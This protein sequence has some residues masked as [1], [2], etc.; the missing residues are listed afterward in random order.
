MPALVPASGP[1][2]MTTEQPKR[3]SD[4]EAQTLPDDVELEPTEEAEAPEDEEDKE[5]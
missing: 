2:Y 5:E 3:L 4:F 1:V